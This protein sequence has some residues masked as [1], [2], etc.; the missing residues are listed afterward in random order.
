MEKIIFENLPST[1][2][3]LNA[4]N[5]NQLQD[6]VEQAIEI[7]KENIS[8]N[9]VKIL[10]VN[11]NPTQSIDENT[12]INLSNDD[13][14]VIL[15]VARYSSTIDLCVSGYSIKGKGVNLS[16]V[17][18][19]GLVRWRRIQYNSD[20]SYTIIYDANGGAVIPIYAIGY[21]I[22]LI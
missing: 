6:N 15:W 17:T 22:G 4:E 16:N 5:L 12:N 11:P 1:K 13:Y 14:D 8:E 18:S 21:K 9:G 20:T 3:P 19:D 7:L 10:W 2:T